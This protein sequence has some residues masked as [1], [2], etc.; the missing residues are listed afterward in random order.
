M[1]ATLRHATVEHYAAPQCL[2]PVVN[3]V[4]YLPLMLL[5]PVILLVAAIFLRDPIY[6]AGESVLHLLHHEGFYAE[7]F[8]HWLLQ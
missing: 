4:K 2:G 8:P 3:Q 5:V 1:L 6:A 7:L